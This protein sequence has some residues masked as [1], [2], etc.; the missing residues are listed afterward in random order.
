MSDLLPSRDY[1]VAE[2]LDCFKKCGGK[3]DTLA[4]FTKAPRNTVCRWNNDRLPLGETMLRLQ[5]FFSVVDYSVDVFKNM[6]PALIKLGRCIA[7]DLVSTDDVVRETG[8]KDAKNLLACLR[9]AAGISQAKLEIIKGICVKNHFLLLNAV[10][11]FQVKYHLGSSGKPHS[12][13]IADFAKACE[14]VRLFGN[15]LL[16]GPIEG[17]IEM[18]KKM[19]QGS[20]EPPLHLTWEVLNKLLKE[21]FVKLQ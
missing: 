15:Q 4:Q 5:H 7:F 2:C 13:L 19:G 8:F 9:G 16:D 1:S 20:N 14:Q 12:D 17:R 6:D 11:A 18:R 21:P 3:L 10:A